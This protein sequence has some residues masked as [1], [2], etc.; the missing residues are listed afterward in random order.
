MSN[1]PL[2]N[3]VVRNRLYFVFDKISGAI[4]G[5]TSAV[6]DT[7]A[8]RNVLSTLMYP[9][10]DTELYCYGEVSGELDPDS[11][12]V[13]LN[14]AYKFDFFEPQ[15]VS[16]SCYKFPET[17]ADS[18]SELGLTKEEMEQFNLNNNHRGN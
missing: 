7:M 2:Q 5:F 1:S 18:L 3:L 17:V 15:F 9:L 8:V 10:K 12:Q 16:W 4:S 14:Q 13:I 11:K 6:N